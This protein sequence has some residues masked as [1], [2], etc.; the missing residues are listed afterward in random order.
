MLETFQ[1]QGY[2][3]AENAITPKELDVLRTVCN[4]L[5][6]EPVDD[7]GKNCHRI[8]RGK[9]RQFLCH[10]HQEFPLLENLVKTGTP[11]K[12]A[13]EIFGP[14]FYLFNEQFVVKGPKTGAGFAWHQDGAYVGFDHQPYLSVWIALDDIHSQNGSLKILP[15]NL[16]TSSYLEDHVWDEKNS[17]LNGYSGKEEGISVYCKKGSIVLFSSLT[18]HSSGANTSTKNRRA[19]LI[20]YSS[21]PIIDPQNQ[22]P[23]RFDSAISL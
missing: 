5:L 3:L 4:Q 23:K 21:T 13:A 19:Y 15:R 14:E 1:K 18:L 12:F 9:D 2:Y 17:E 8:G 6:E 22:E 20:Q 11:A 7:G 10:R 16:I